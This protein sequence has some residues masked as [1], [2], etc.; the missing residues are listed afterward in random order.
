MSVALLDQ[1]E[2]VPARGT[3]RM[4][5]LPELQDVGLGSAQG[6][7]RIDEMHEVT[8][9]ARDGRVE[10]RQAVKEFVDPER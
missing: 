9:E 5:R 1:G 6:T 4:R 7:L 8:G 3:T 2:I 10:R